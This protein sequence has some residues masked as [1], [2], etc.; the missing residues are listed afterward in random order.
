VPLSRAEQESDAPKGSNQTFQVKYGQWS[1]LVYWIF[2]D[3]NGLSL[4]VTNFHFKPK[5]L[6]AKKSSIFDYLN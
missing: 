1:W 3:I 5:K 6:K 2:T 4:I